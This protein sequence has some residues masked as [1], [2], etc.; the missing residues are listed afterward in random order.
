MIPFKHA[1]TAVFGLDGIVH[2]GLL[3][4]RLSE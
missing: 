2:V 4:R 1:R 3:E